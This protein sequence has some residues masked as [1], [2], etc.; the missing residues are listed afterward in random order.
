MLCR[1]IWVSFHLI[2]R[3][4]EGEGFLY[5]EVASS[6]QAG[7]LSKTERQESPIY[8]RFC[9]LVERSFRRLI[10]T[11]GMKS[12]ADYVR[13]NRYNGELKQEIVQWIV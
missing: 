6:R 3:P 4:V 1:K 7:F 12:P 2:V 11:M 9:G 5:G 13:M 10:Q 8:R